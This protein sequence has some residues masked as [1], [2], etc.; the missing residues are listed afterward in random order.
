M[1]GCDEF[2]ADPPA[3]PGLRAMPVVFVLIWSTGFVVARLGMPHA[4]PMTFLAWR[5]ALSVAPSCSGSAVACGL[6]ARPHAVAAPGG[7]RR[8]DARRL[9]GR[10][11]GGRQ[12]RGWVPARGADR[13]PAAGAD[14]V[15]M[16][17]R[18]SEHRVTPRQW[19]GPA[20]GP[21][22]LVLVVWHKLGLGE[23]QAGQPGAGG[24]GAGQHHGR[25]AVPEALGR[26]LRRAHRQ[27]GAALPRLRGDGAAGLLETE[28]MELAPRTARRHGLVGARADAGRQFAAVPADPARRR[29]PG[30]QPDVPG[31]ARAPRCWPGCCSASHDPA[32]VLPAWRSRPSASAWCVRE[33]G[34]AAWPLRA[35][36]RPGFVK[37]ASRG[38]CGS[39][40]RVPRTQG[41]ES[42]ASL[43]T[44]WGRGCNES[45]GWRSAS[46]RAAPP[47]RIHTAEHL[48]RG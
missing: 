46:R 34:G 20:A 42:A 17:A 25:H 9:P 45:A 19:L 31:A 10:R 33:G 28:G 2:P 35:G 40:A 22:G 38:Q 8:A 4:P 5:Y 3:G 16:S 37:R 24:A 7:H 12:A 26:A 14:G 43:D 30:H 32:R 6:A 21:G 11:V 39:R 23:V 1:S 41:I 18:G 27:L 15:W 48:E 13:R 29:H 36:L 47:H 44:A